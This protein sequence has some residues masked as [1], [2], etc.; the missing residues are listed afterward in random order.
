M[1]M[2][3]IEALHSILVVAGNILCS[4]L[5]ESFVCQELYKERSKLYRFVGTEWKER[6]TGEARLLKDGETGV[7]RFVMRQEK[8]LKVAANHTVPVDAELRPNLGSDKSWV[9][10]AG[11]FADGTMQF[12]K[13]AIRFK[14]PESRCI[15]V[16]FYFQS[17]PVYFLLIKSIGVCV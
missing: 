11:D 17:M 3:W 16:I 4:F 6:G 12:E 15:G 1:G 10:A 13:F 5:I 9:W 14:T 8:T 2:E 7:V